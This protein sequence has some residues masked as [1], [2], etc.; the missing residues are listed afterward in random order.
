MG[1]YDLC[2]GDGCLA[3]GKIEGTPVGGS[4][5]LGGLE[6]QMTCTSRW[7]PAPG[8]GRRLVHTP[9]QVDAVNRVHRWNC[10]AAFRALLDCRWPIRCHRISMSVAAAIFC[11]ASCTR[12]RQIALAR[13]IRRADGVEGEGLGDGDEP[14]VGGKPSRARGRIGHARANSARRWAIVENGTQS[15][16]RYSCRACYSRRALL[17]ELREHPWPEP[18]TVRSGASGRYFSNAA[19]LRDIA[20]VE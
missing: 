18:Q 17:L 6:R 8:S 19:W 5:M 16:Q 15:Q 4:A 14:D 2:R 12:F 13:L 1:P 11:R 20:R 7:G 9:Q 10:S 3:S